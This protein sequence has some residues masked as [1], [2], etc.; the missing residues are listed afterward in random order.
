M[1]PSPTLPSKA[2][3]IAGKKFGRLTVECFTGRFDRRSPIWICRCVCGGQREAIATRLRCG[4]VKSCGCLHRESITTHGM[5]KSPTYRIWEGMIRRC[6]NPK[7]KEFRNYGGRGIKVCSRWMSFENF[8]AD[9]GERPSGMSIDR[10][11]NS[12]GYSPQNCRWATRHA[13]MRNTRRN[14]W[15]VFSGIRLVRKDW[16]KRLGMAPSTLV[17]RLQKWP[18]AKALTEPVKKCT[19]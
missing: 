6:L 4:A 16:A 13:Q 18:L 10:K 9:M 11:D 17:K 2:I 12:G 14:V 15:V 19:S 1:P 3:D 8:F 5:T 7:N